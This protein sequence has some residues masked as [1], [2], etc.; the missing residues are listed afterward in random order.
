MSAPVGV[1]CDLVDVVRFTALLERRPA[2]VRRLFTDTEC[3]DARRRPERLA[4]RFAAKEATWKALGV[5][6]GA[7]GFHDVEVRRLPSGAPV[8]HLSGRAAHLA[9]ERGVDHWLLS[10][11]H[12]ATSALATVIGASA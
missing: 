8:L 5:G 11:S 1:G 2:M 10:L 9:R 4:A 7:V 3:L 6:V 12:T